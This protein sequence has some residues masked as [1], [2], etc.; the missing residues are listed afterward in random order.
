[1]RRIHEPR[2]TASRAH[3]F[4]RRIPSP[5]PARPAASGSVIAPGHLPKRCMGWG[6][7]G[8]SGV[9][10]ARYARNT[11]VPSAVSRKDC[12]YR[13]VPNRD[14]LTPP[15]CGLRNNRAKSAKVKSR[16]IARFPSSCRNAM[17]GCCVADRPSTDQSWK[18]RECA[19]RTSNR[20]GRG[21]IRRRLTAGCRRR[22]PPYGRS[23]CFGGCD[24]WGR[25]P[26]RRSSHRRPCVG[27]WRCR[28]RLH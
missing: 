2:P 4:S 23:Q 28:C 12:S 21:R 19:V 1:M 3:P 6:D 5:E 14:L 24:A 15:V 22:D 27:G 16:W 20:A 25:I 26:L 13:T 9:T 17:D 8:P 10:N 7:R 11:L 18:A